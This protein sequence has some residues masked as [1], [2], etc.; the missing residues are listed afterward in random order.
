M[1]ETATLAVPGASL[2]YERRGAGPV[3]LLIPGGNGDA[4]P[5]AAVA[6]ALADRY[7]VVAY[8]RRGFARSPLDRPLQPGDDEHRLAADV[9][10]AHRLLAHLGGGP[11]YVLGSSSGALVALGLM[12]RHPGDVRLLMPHE[13]P[14]LTL[15]PDGDDIARGADGV[16]A[17]YRESGPE[18]AMAEF[19]AVTFG[20]P[21]GSGGFSGLRPDGPPPPGFTEMAARMRHNIPFWIEHELRQYPRH[22]IDIEALRPHADRIAPLCGR[23]SR[24]Q[25][26]YRPNTVLAERLGRT[27][28]E[29]PGGH[30]GYMTHPDAFAAELAP[31]LAAAPDVGPR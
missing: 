2:Y 10:D 5:Y 14:A 22:P 4:L 24:G 18:A 23:D 19:A 13:P 1:I 7:T 25:Y 27:I 3:L 16:Y 9:D 15:L 11:A 17:T 30:V 20:G 6:E 29:L 21:G 8:E 31:V 12:A 28:T 26:P